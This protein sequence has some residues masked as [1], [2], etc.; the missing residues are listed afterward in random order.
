MMIMTRRRT[1]T[2]MLTFRECKCIV[3]ILETSDGVERTIQPCQVV[4]CRF[5]HIIN[6]RYLAMR[7]FLMM[8]IFMIILG[9]LGISFGFHHHHH[10]PHL[11]DHG[12]AL[13]N[14]LKAD[15]GCIDANCRKPQ[16]FVGRVSRVLRISSVSVT[17]RRMRAALTTTF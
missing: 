16:G 2:M 15:R 10:H 13:C 8:A 6:S 4:C 7:A 17:L 3:A 11:N 1:R 14:R 5:L 9:N 12:A